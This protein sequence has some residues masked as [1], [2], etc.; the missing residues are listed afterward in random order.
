MSLKAKIEVQSGQ[1]II[2]VLIFNSY[3]ISPKTLVQTPVG[4]SLAEKELVGGTDVCRVAEE[5]GGAC[6]VVGP[7][8]AADLNG[9][10]RWLGR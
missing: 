1:S 9:G 10:P 4:S 5:P 6:W 3:G 2:P 7:L 8:V